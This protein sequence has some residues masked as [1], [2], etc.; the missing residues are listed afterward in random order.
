VSEEG[1]GGW[2][3]KWKDR[4]FSISLVEMSEGD[5]DI[6]TAS[7]WTTT[8]YMPVQVVYELVKDE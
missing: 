2:S 8:D 1:D 4:K 5:A 3:V 6:V 7:A